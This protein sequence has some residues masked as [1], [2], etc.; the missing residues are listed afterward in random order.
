MDIVINSHNDFRNKLIG[1]PDI[2]MNVVKNVD[3]FSDLVKLCNTS[4]QTRIYCSKYQSEY[5]F[6]LIKYNTKIFLFFFD[7]K[8]FKISKYITL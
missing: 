1:L 5:F 4:V 8:E 6:N 7:F 3:S 2:Y